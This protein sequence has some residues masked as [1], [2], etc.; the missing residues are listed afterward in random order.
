M[1]IIFAVFASLAV[2]FRHRLFAHHCVVLPGHRVV[3]FHRIVLRETQG[4]D[5]ESQK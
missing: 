3:L 2:L 4:N 5:A 1:A